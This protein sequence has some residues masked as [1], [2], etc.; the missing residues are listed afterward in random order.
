MILRVTRIELARVFHVK[1]FVPLADAERAA[2]EVDRPVGV[3]LTEL[4]LENRRLLATAVDHRPGEIEIAFL[5]G[6]AIELHQGHLDALM[7]RDVLRLARTELAIEQVGQPG[8]DVQE[9][10]LP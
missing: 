5:A 3:E 4:P 7:P 10:L 2:E 9:R 6:D 1:P 8:R